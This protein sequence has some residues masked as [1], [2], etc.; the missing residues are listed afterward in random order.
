MDEGRSHPCNLLHPYCEVKTVATIRAA[1]S[2]GWGD[3]VEQGK[4][5]RLIRDFER[6]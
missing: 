4:L 5:P 6:V 1:L 3:S 2:A